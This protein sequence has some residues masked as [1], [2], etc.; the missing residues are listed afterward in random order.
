[1]PVSQ[2]VMSQ[3]HAQQNTAAARRDGQ[4]CDVMWASVSCKTSQVCVAV[5]CT[6]K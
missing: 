1:M 3:N 5:W 6:V 4:H 2:N